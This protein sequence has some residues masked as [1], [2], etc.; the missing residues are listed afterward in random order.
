[1]GM[2]DK[3]I[4]RLLQEDATL[5][6][7]DVAKRVGLSTTPCWHLVQELEEDG[8]IRRRATPPTSRS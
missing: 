5:A 3:K 6:V 2:P 8:I 7:A 4:L 1:M